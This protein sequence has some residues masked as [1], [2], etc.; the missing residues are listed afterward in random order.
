M[1]VP[2]YAWTSMG[3]VLLVFIIAGLSKATQVAPR[4]SPDRV[5]K[6]LL[7][8]AAQKLRAAQQDGKPLQQLSDAHFGMAYV[9][10]SRMLSTSDAALA[11]MTGVHV[12][13]LHASLRAQQEAAYEGLTLRHPDLRL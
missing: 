5:A 10:A 6:Q 2:L 1:K 4:T 11:G 13:D 9:N 12:G 7:E 8:A 3:V